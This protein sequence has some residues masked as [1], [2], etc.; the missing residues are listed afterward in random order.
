M[1]RAMA[2]E[3]KVIY[4]TLDVVGITSNDCAPPAA[5]VESRLT[6]TSDPA[7]LLRIS[8]RHQVNH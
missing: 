1:A 6:H 3:L 5:I 7:L 8:W 4:L 2:A